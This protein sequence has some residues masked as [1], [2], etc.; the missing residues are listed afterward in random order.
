MK[1]AISPMLFSDDEIAEAKDTADPVAKAQPSESAKNKKARKRTE[2]DVPICSFDTLMTILASMAQVK[3]R[4]PKTEIVFEQYPIPT[5]IQK[6]AF[7]LL[8]V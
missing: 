3:Q 1:Q 5:P 4:I 7:K 2:D 8:G 6:K